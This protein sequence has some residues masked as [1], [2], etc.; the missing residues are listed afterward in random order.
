VLIDIWRRGASEV[1]AIVIKIYKYRRV[2]GGKG[3]SSYKHFEY[4][5]QDRNPNTSIARDRRE[6]L[7]RGRRSGTIATHEIIPHFLPQSDVE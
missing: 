1:R 6:K 3:G 4:K 5:E 2:G 7:L